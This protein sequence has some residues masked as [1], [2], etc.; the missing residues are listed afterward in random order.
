MI[1]LALMAVLAAAPAE[2]ACAPST[3][4]ETP[5]CAEGRG[6]TVADLGWSSMECDCTQRLSND[7]AQRRT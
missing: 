4:G 6:V 5:P 7:W 2:A 3:G 1:T